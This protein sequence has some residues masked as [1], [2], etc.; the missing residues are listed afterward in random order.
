MVAS[1]LIKYLY[2]CLLE[3]RRE[4]TP[5]KSASSVAVEQKELQEQQQQQQQVETVATS[6]PRF[7]QLL[8]ATAESRSIVASQLTHATG[9]EL[10]SQLAASGESQLLLAVDRPTAETVMLGTASAA[11]V[12][13]PSPHD[14]AV[15]VDHL[16][17]TTRLL[18][19]RFALSTVGNIIQVYCIRQVNGVKL[20]DILFSLHVCL[21]VRPS[22]C[23]QS[24][25]RCKYLENGLRQRLGTNY[26]LIGNGLWRIE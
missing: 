6:E 8:T 12:E 21:C 14:G 19:R 13:P 23:A 2:L 18:T 15:A 10:T 1:V 9:V 20:A 16:E 17:R 7:Q 26:Q 22:V 24:V 3:D 11:E 5:E 4:T 25:F